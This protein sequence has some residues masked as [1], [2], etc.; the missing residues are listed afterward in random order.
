M[1][2]TFKLEIKANKKDIWEMYTNIDKR[3]IWE[4]N[5]IDIHLDKGFQK[6]SKGTFELKGMPKMNM[7]IVEIEEFSKIVDVTNALFGKIYFKL[8]IIEENEKTFIKHSAEVEESVP[9]QILLG[10][11]SGTPEAMGKMKTYVESK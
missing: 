9:M 8:E 5:L 4:E 6:D 11:F 7:E 1:K 10:I 3:K 2:I